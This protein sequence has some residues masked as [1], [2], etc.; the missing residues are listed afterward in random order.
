LANVEFLHMPYNKGLLVVGNSAP[1]IKNQ[2]G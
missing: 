2:E 1:I